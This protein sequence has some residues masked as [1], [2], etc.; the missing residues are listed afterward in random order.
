MALGCEANEAWLASSSILLRGYMR[1]AMRRSE[2]G[3]IMR[4]SADT[5]Y[6]VGF[7]FH[8]GDE[9]GSPN[10]EP[11]GA[12]CVTAITSASSAE[13]SWQ[14]LSWNLSCLIHT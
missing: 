2:S 8:A 12:F 7:Y 14:K 5:W 11:T 9:T 13:R 4:S 3:G 10:V 1:S 6:Q